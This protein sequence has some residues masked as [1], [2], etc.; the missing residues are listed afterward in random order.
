MLFGSVTSSASTRSRSERGSAPSRGVRIV[1]TTF[2]SRSRK[3]RAVSR[4]N[5]D[6]HPVIKIVFIRA[7]V[8]GGFQ[9]PEATASKPDVLRQEVRISLAGVRLWSIRSQK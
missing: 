5:P 1:A 2:H 9:H 8:A 6:E 3:Y 7:P 4:P